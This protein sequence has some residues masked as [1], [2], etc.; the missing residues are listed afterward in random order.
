MKIVD[1]VNKLEEIEKESKGKAKELCGLLIDDLIEYDLEMS[2]FMSKVNRDVMK[3][4]DREDE[5]LIDYLISQGIQ[6]GSI[7]EA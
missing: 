3:S 6:S 7:G 1:L 2:K 4:M 5:S